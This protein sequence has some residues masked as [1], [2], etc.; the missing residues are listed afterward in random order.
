MYN[1]LTG[2]HQS[3]PPQAMLHMAELFVLLIVTM[4]ME[5]A[6]ASATA[7]NLCPCAFSPLLF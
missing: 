5:N 1:G 6:T 3:R 4:N 7:S 2:R